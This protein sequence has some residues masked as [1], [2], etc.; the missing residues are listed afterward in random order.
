MVG[1]EDQNPN[2]CSSLYDNLLVI[3][4][5]KNLPLHNRVSDVLSAYQYSTC[6]TPKTT[7]FSFT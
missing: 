4:Q 5:E 7:S 1:N 6:P 3:G 2:L